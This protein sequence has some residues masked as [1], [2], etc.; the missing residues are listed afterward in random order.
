MVTFS[1]LMSPSTPS[2]VSILN[3]TVSFASS[4]E[5][6]TVVTVT[7]PLVWPAGIVIVLEDNV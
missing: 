4:A 1:V 5:S 6:L 7:D 2:T 3:T